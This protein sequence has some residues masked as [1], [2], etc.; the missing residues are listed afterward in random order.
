[1]INKQI[2]SYFSTL[3]YIC[4]FCLNLK[5]FEL[6]RNKIRIAEKARCVSKLHFF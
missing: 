4:K 3:I 6:Y 1:M 2:R 5:S